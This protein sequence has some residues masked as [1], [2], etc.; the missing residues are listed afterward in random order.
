MPNQSPNNEFNKAI[1][2]LVNHLP[3][4]T[5]KRN[6]AETIITQIEFDLELEEKFPFTKSLFDDLVFLF[7]DTE[8]AIDDIEHLQYKERY[9]FKR[10]SEK[11]VLDFEYNKNGFW[12]Y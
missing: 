4:I 9:T 12:D 6:T 10:N 1:A 5:V 3:N 11:A 8:I 2:E 7:K